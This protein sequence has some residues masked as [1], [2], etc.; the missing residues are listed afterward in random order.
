MEIQ[1]VA[2]GP[3]AESRGRRGTASV[4]N[5]FRAWVWIGM[6]DR[7]NHED[8]HKGAMISVR[9]EGGL[10]WRL[11]TVRVGRPAKIPRW[12]KAMRTCSQVEASQDCRCAAAL[13]PACRMPSLE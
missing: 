8:S 9:I 12:A 4:L 5:E 6:P 1:I 7:S 2:V 11:A 13:A 3:D 10:G